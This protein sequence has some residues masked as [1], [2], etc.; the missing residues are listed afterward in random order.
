[1]SSSRFQIGQIAS[2]TDVLLARHAISPGAFNCFSV[3]GIRDE[4]LALLFDI[5]HQTGET[6]VSPGYPNTEKR[7]AGKYDAQRSIFDEIRDV[8]L[9]DE[10]L[11]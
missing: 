3:S 6:C 7:V 5:L 10:T 11:S 9:A 8:W 4:A 2:N 1:M